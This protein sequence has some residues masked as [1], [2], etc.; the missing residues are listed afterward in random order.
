MPASP[1]AVSY[2]WNSVSDECNL[3]KVQANTS[4]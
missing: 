3:G 2:L 1:I 4:K